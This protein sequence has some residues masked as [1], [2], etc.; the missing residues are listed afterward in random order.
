MS[1]AADGG[2]LIASLPNPGLINPLLVLAGELAHRDGPPLRFAGTDDQRAAVEAITGANRPRFVGLGPHRDAV[3]PA[4]WD[5]DTYRALTTGSRLSRFSAFLDAAVDSE[6]GWGKYEALLAE[7]DRAKPALVV[8]DS[9]T[10]WAMDAAAVRGIPYLATVAMPVSSVYLD[11]LPWSYP[12][13]FSGLGRQLP[14]GDKVANAL[15]RLGCR[16]AVMAPKRI[17]EA[18]PVVKRRRAAGVPNPMGLPSRHADA[19][20][21]VLAFTV[22]ELDYPFPALPDNVRY[23]GAMVP[24]DQGRTADDD[25]LPWLDEHESVVYIGFGTIMRPTAG[26][27]RALVETARA[28]GPEHHVLWKLPV[29][30]QHLLPA[31]LPANLRVTGWVPSQ[32]DVLAHPSVRVF[33]NHGGGNGVNEGLRFGKPLLV[34]PFWMDCHDYAARVVDSGAGLSVPHETDPDPAVLTALLVRLLTEDVF[35]VRAAELAES[36]RKA[37]GVVAAA[38]EVVRAWSA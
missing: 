15:F 14:L 28:L 4:H 21:S 19:A 38:D 2:V 27:V 32:V 24:A 12:T 7:I 8:A 36:H 16:T 25:V 1:T 20:V 26:Q 6:Y 17:K 11:R 33:F 22:P 10:S 35:R 23:V 9:S 34:L 3:D 30:Q 5:D 29:A 31:D 18:A 13:P 37:G